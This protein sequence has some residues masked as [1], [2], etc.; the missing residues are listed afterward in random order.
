MSAYVRKTKCRV[1]RCSQPGCVWLGVFFG[2][3]RKDVDTE[4]RLALALHL[5]KHLLETIHRRKP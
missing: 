3:D 2:V 1:L 4:A 5:V